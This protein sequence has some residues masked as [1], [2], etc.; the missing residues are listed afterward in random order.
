M[1]VE[2]QIDD[3]TIVRNLGYFS[4]MV[5]AIGFGIFALANSIAFADR[6]RAALS[7]CPRRPLSRSHI[8]RRPPDTCPSGNTT[9]PHFPRRLPVR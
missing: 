1:Q 9:G 7:Q 4:L 5:I 6:R 8:A 3:P 2:S